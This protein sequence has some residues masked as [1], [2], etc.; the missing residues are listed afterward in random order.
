MISPGAEPQ[1]D[2]PAA[3]DVEIGIRQFD[4]GLSFSGMFS[5]SNPIEVEIGSGRG[6]FIITSAR[7]NPHVNYLGIERAYKFFHFMKERVEEARV[8][9]VRLLRAE[10]DYF[11]WGY[12]PPESVQA[13]HIYFPD[14]WPKTKH[15]RRR[16]VNPDFFDLLRSRLV[17]GGCIHLATDF[18]QYFEIMLKTGRG[19][20]GLEE[21][22]CRTIDPAGLDPE[23]AATHYERRFFMHGLPVY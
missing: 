10:A 18:V 13:F 20:A 9:N 7:E 4:D 8:D 5:N 21:L 19:C 11:L 1:Q 6:R 3:R 23:S 16:I 14:P 15:R 2:A 17:P 12:V 22:Y